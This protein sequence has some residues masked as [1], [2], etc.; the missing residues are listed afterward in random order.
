LAVEV[1]EPLMPRNSVAYDEDFFA[2]TQEQARLL[3]AGEFSQMDVENVA[4]ELESM[5]R[6]DKRELRS[7]LVLLIMHLLK[8]QYQP[9]FRSRSCTS[10]IGEQ[11]DQVKEVLDDSPSLRP[12]VATDLSRTYKLAR[13]KAVGE[14]GLTEKTFPETCPYT[15]EQILSEDFLPE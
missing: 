8:W 2:W 6:S 11:R 10:T 9:G 7:R 5:G 14:T 15:P 3:R 1:K 12:T 13:I 4:E